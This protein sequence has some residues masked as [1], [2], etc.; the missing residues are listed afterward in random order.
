MEQGSERLFA[1]SFQV[2]DGAQSMLA[3]LSEAKQQSILKALQEGIRTGKVR[4]PSAYVVGAVQAADAQADK[5]GIDQRC[6]EMLAGLPPAQ[7][8]EIISKLKQAPE[9]RNPSA[10][11]MKA[12]ITA[13]Q[14]P[15]E[16]M[17]QVGP[18]MV[19]PPLPMAMLQHMQHFQPLQVVRAA[20]EVSSG[21]LVGIDS[22]ALALLQTLNPMVQ[23]D[24]LLK[25]QSQPD[26]RNPSAWVAKAAM[27]AGASS[28]RGPLAQQMQ[29]L[30]VAQFF[31]FAQPVPVGMMA[32][33]QQ[34]L[35]TM[36]ALD[37]QATV[38]LETLPLHTQ[39]DILAKLQAQIGVRNPSAWVAKAALAAGATPQS[40][41]TKGPQMAK[42][43]LDA[44]ASNLLA[45]LSPTTQEGILLKLHDAKDAGTVRNVSAWVVKA[46][47][48]AGASASKSGGKVTSGSMRASLRP[49]PY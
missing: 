25:L 39:Q 35:A 12:V 31:P 6:Q 26:V 9:V 13:K 15:Q 45:T 48:N 21:V 2:D 20:P 46:A 33:P 4:N 42:L 43:D 17:V 14:A 5:M 11:V 34:H 8:S 28:L 19:H 7:R 10:W 44:E 40:V 23:Q 47:L 18:A 38:L 41:V 32:V 3:E 24:I 1:D 27:A 16:P 49:S 29:Q 22:G 30:P 36:V 37:Q